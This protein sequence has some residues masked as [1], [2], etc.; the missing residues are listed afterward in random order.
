VMIMGE[1]SSH[2]ESCSFQR[3]GGG[4]NVLYLHVGLFF[5]SCTSPGVTT[6]LS[7]WV[8]DLI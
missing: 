5:K 3:A 2:L 7:T 4:T 1:K 8:V 6:V